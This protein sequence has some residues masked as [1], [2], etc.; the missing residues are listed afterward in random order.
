MVLRALVTRSN[1]KTEDGVKNKFHTLTPIEQGGGH[2]EIR[3]RNCTHL[4]LKGN[5][6]PF[7]T[8]QGAY[9]TKSLID[10]PWICPGYHKKEGT[11]EF[12]G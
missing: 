4:Q 6:H 11:G 8:W 5:P 2:R 7:C 9:I 3:C 10:Q 1:D 12:E